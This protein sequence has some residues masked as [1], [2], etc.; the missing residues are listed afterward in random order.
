M[1]LAGPGEQKGEIFGNNLTAKKGRLGLNLR[2]FG[3]EPGFCWKN[4][5]MK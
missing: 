3:M 5:W 1:S 4:D 2:G